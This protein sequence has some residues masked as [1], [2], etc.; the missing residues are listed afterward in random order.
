VVL[1][2][3]NVFNLDF[4]FSLYISVVNFWAGI[5]T[6]YHSSFHINLC[7]RDAVPGKHCCSGLA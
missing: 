1:Q 2:S 6:W 5:P 4:G 7:V 3:G